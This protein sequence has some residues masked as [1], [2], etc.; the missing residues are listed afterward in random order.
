MR[1]KKIIL[2][3]CAD[4]GSDSYPYQEDDGYE[5]I[6]IGKEIGVENY[7]PDRPIHGVIANPVCTEFSTARGFHKKGEPDLSMLRHCQRIIDE[8]EPEWWIIEN[9]YNGTMKEYLGPPDYTYEPWMYGSPWTKRTALWGTFYAPDE[10]YTSWEDVPKNDKLYTR[11]G[12]PKPSIAFLHKSAIHNIPEFEK[13]IPSIN[14][15]NG[16]RSLCSQ[17]FAEAF[18]KV[19]P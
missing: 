15:D 19:N 9:P 7:H 8:V 16:F 17:G 6:K 5:V 18:K 2:H 4:I 1:S 11:P 3:L 14:D 10:T 13:F 12:R